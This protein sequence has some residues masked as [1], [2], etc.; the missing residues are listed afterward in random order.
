MKTAIVKARRQLADGRRLVNVVCPLC[1]GCHWLPAT[2]ETAS[3]PRRP[4]GFAL[5]KG[6]NTMIDTTTLFTPTDI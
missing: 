2:T 6:P 4:G 5:P 1:D 3:C